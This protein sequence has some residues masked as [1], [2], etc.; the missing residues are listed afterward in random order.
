[1]PYPSGYNF[2]FVFRRDG[3]RFLQL[4]YPARDLG[5]PCGF[6]TEYNCIQTT[7]GVTSFRMV[8]M[9]CGLGSSLYS[10]AGCPHI[11]VVKHECQLPML[12][13]KSLPTV[14]RHEA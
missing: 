14:G 11:H 3:V 1:M 6:L 2:S 8:E 5:L 4:P 13:Y 12:P 7:N 9:R 10:G